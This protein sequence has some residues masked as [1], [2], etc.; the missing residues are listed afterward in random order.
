[1]RHITY[2]IC[3]NA[4]VWPF[5]KRG[6]WRKTYPVNSSRWN[7]IQTKARSKRL[8]RKDR[9]KDKEG[10][11]EKCKKKKKKKDESIFI[12]IQTAQFPPRP[13]K[14]QTHSTV[15]SVTLLSMSPMCRRA[16]TLAKWQSWQQEAKRE[17]ELE[18]DNN[19][20]SLSHEQ[21]GVEGGRGEVRRRR[22]GT[23]RQPAAAIAH[24]MRP[25]YGKKQ[26]NNPHLLQT[27]HSP[28]VCNQR[29]LI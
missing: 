10:E 22:H 7:D 11:R 24:R 29:V 17:Q 18:N 12:T 23:T 25:C 5:G 13:V 26:N 9:K 27:D 8:W 3:G 6:G 15:S 14:L 1:M 19:R 20:V 16:H 2:G 28:V 4:F 21:T